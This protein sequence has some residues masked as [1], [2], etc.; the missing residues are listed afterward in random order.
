M[1]ILGQEQTLAGAFKFRVSAVKRDSMKLNIWFSIACLVLTTTAHAAERYEL[2]D[3][4]ILEGVE[5]FDGSLP[6]AALTILGVTLDENKFADVRSSLGSSS[7]I[8][9]AS[10]PHD[11]DSICYSS[12]VDHKVRLIFSSGGPE[13]PTDKLTSFT[14]ASDGASQKNEH[15]STSNN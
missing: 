14:L 4:T 3:G 10:H 2:S 15:C 5:R 7:E 12:A 1:G 8:L 11:A 9:K 6:K 13:D